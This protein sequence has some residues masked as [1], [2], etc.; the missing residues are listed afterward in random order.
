VTCIPGVQVLV[1]R[2]RALIIPY[3]VKEYNTCIL[4]VPY[5]EQDYMIFI[6]YIK[7][8]LIFGIAIFS[9]R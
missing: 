9:N 2:M 8:R 3:P 5:R 4:L 1:R 7:R 6:R